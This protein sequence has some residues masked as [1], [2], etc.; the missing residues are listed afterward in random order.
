MIRA[1]KPILYVDDTEEQR[2]ALC[3]ILEREGYRPIQAATGSEALSKLHPDLLA[4]VLD[5][6][7]PDMSGYEVCR[8]IKQDPIY[9]A[10]PVVQVS[11]GFADPD[12]RA[13]G[14]SGGADSYIAQPVHP[15]EL[16]NLIRSLVRS[17]EAERMLRF[18]A[19]IGP[20]ITRS[21]DLAETVQAI[22]SSVPPF[23]ADRC[24]LVLS[25]D[26]SP[27]DQ[28]PI[29]KELKELADSSAHGNAI[30]LRTFGSACSVIA[31][32][33]RNAG[34]QLG[35]VLF[36]LDS[37]A[38]S[39]TEADRVYAGDLAERIALAIS[40]AQLYTAQHAAQEALVQSEKLAAAGRLSAA[41][42]HELNNPLEAI[43][44]LLYLIETDPAVSDRARNYAK[45][46]LS[47]LERLSHITRQSLGFYRELTS[48]QEFD[49][50][51]NVQDTLS[52]YARRL[53]AKAIRI[54]T[55]FDAS[56]TVH[57]IRGEIRQV[58]SNLIVNAL[59]AMDYGGCLSVRT[60]RSASGQV[61]V[62][63]RDNGP[64]IPE[65]VQSRMFEPFFTTKPGTG[66]GLGLW[67]S[68]TIIRKHKGRLEVQSQP[69]SG[70]R[71]T[72]MSILLP[73]SHHEL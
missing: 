73:S 18:M 23:F 11:A 9:A 64:G 46:A 60:F 6:K 68:D 47:E 62:S 57:A 4:V 16:L 7:L 63:I 51:E 67:V 29:S 37:G 19:Q 28:R 43:T 21:L 34:K 35:A 71:G 32:P 59:D 42:A 36:V 25:G 13:V 53:S 56:L 52:L 26:Q 24:V 38:R 70:I 10:V 15:Q 65:Q 27:D 31:V 40:N 54:E 61:A 12:H 49:V 39:Y 2:Y 8:R 22:E 14:L 48:A 17:S 45:E 58:I 55:E 44:N 1:D 41:I 66:T 72:T 3:R 5:V 33:L 50:S 30:E 69:E 20:Q